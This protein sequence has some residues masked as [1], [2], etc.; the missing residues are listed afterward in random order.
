MEEQPDPIAGAVK[1]GFT[2]ESP[3][4]TPKRP[5]IHLDIQLKD[6]ENNVVYFPDLC[7][8]AGFTVI[9]TPPRYLSGSES[10]GSETPH[11]DWSDNDTPNDFSSPRPSSSGDPLPPPVHEESNEF[12]KRLLENAEKYAQEAQEEKAKE[13]KEKPEKNPKKRKEK[14]SKK[15]QNYDVSDPFIDDSDLAPFQRDYGNIRPTVEGFFV[16]KGPLT[17]QGMVDET[18]TGKKRTKRKPKSGDA[19]D[20]PPQPRKKRTVK[21]KEGEEGSDKINKPKR[22]YKRLLTTNPTEAPKTPTF[23]NKVIPDPNKTPGKK[24]KIYPIE[25][26]RPEIQVLVDAFK[27]KVDSETFEI[28]SRFPPNLKPPLME[29]LTAAYER[30]Q[31]NENLFKILTNILPYNKFTVT[32]LCQRTLY[33]KTISELHKTK[34][35]LIERLKAA[36]EEVMPLLIQEYNERQ[37]TRALLDSTSATSNSESMMDIDGETEQYQDPNGKKFRWDETTRSLLWKI[38]QAE[39]SIVVMSNDLWEAEEKSERYSEQTQR[40]HLYQNLLT[41]WPSGWMTSYEI[42]RVYSAYKR[43]LRDRQTTS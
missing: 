13:A 42:A 25:P 35:D 21:P 7:E 37:A 9:K 29:I 28:K 19:K 12:F 24:K 10:V 43:Y 30:S 20:K 5:D 6:K 41:V 27:V 33:P 16:W 8:A 17:L 18:E 31:F 38:V 22:A 32:R 26:I 2:S 3:Q 15:E 1:L 36:V 40:K 14:V 4:Q 23:N 34:A 39:M 11:S